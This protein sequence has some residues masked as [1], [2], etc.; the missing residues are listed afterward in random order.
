M[1]QVSYQTSSQSRRSGKSIWP[2]THRQS[3]ALEPSSDSITSC[4]LP[5]PYGDACQHVLTSV[6]DSCGFLYHGSAPHQDVPN[7]TQ[8]TRRRKTPKDSRLEHLG[9]DDDG[10]PLFYGSASQDSRTAAADLTASL[11]LKIL[12]VDRTLTLLIYILHK[13]QVCKETGWLKMVS[14]NKRGPLLLMTRAIL[15]TF[16]TT[17][18]KI[19]AKIVDNDED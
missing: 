7:T 9:Q 4:H 10:T 12:K 15:E 17:I 6:I 11:A 13:A 8:Y 3:G 16:Y 19:P 2:P 1:K 5:L 14:G 18:M